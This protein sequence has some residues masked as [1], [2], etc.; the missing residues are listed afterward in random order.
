MIHEI[1]PDLEKVLEVTSPLKLGYATWVPSLY[2]T[3]TSK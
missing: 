1:T 3:N 2:A